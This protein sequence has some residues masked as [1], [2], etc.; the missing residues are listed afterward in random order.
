MRRILTT[1]LLIGVFSTCG[2]V[3]CAEK[4]EYKTEQTVK[5]PGGTTTTTNDTT[6]KKTGENPP[7]TPA[8]ETAKP[9]Q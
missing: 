8:D 1:A 7:P 5:S 9:P 6:V 4:E 2:F 3:G